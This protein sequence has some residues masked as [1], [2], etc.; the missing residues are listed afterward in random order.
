MNTEF[1]KTFFRDLKKITDPALK[2]AIRQVIESVKQA[3]TMPDIPNLQKM[4]G[5]K[6]D[7]FTVSGLE[8]IVSA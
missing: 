8:I 2:E 4:K 7:I 3:K 1:K 6:N 5:Y